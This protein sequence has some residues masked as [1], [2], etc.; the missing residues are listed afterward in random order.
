[1]ATFRLRRF[2]HPEAL[3]AIDPAKLSLF[4][5]RF[6][7]YLTRRGFSILQAGVIDY[8]RLV[9]VLMNPDEDV[10]SI[11]VDALYFVHEMADNA[12]TDQLIE[13]AKARHIN[14]DLNSEPTAADV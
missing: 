5:G 10:P 8:E 4:L 2:S 6:A 3:K 11:M 9:H 14:L 1:M 13:A 7:E 12:V